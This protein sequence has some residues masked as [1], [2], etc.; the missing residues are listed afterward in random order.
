V[1]LVQRKGWVDGMSGVPM[2]EQVEAGWQPISS[3]PKDGTPVLVWQ[4]TY[5]PRPGYFSV[6]L[7]AWM[8]DGHP[9]DPTH[10]M[11]LPPSPQE[12]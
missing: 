4:R 12:P 10:W 1:R 5:L 11:P 9:S 7:Q 2:S 6:R 3:A 8:T